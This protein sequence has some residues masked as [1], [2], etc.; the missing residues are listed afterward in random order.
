MTKQISA[1]TIL[2]YLAM[3][4]TPI[5]AVI[6]FGWRV[7]TAVHA[8]TGTN[9]L[10]IPAG[11]AAAV[12]LEMV[13]IFAGH[14]M[15]ELWQRRDGRAW[16]A[17]GI[18]AVYVGIGVIELAGTIG[19]VMFLIAPLVYVLVGLR[20]TVD[21]VAGRETAVSATRL[22]FQLEQARLDREAERERQASNDR[23]QH[24]ENLRK[25]ELEA[26]ASTEQA[27]ITL[28]EKR[29]QA[30]ERRRKREARRAQAEGKRAQAAL[31]S[32]ATEE[33]VLAIYSKDPKASQQS[34]ANQTDVSRQRIGQ[35]LQDLEGRGAISRNGK[36][37][38]IKE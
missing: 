9:W 19:Q 21:E 13:G 8:E 3:F 26:S 34:V 32:M 11:I 25:L 37:V 31:D 30:D 14:L 24:E 15:M 38:V 36:G 4:L 5:G 29:L 12:G 27:A 10:A 1:Y 28:E 22:D 18:M 20:Q 6:F 17:A 7:Y 2:G 33:K 16:L 35:I 23:R